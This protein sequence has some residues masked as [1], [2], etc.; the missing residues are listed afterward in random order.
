MEELFGLSNFRRDRRRIRLALGHVLDERAE[1]LERVG[2]LSRPRAQL[3]DGLAV[4][5]ID[6]CPLAPQ[7]IDRRGQLTRQFPHGVDV[8]PL[9]AR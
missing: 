2:G 6:L 8:T 7:R 1:L 5:A 3:R 9:V 4:F